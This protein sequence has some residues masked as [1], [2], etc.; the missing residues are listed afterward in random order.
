MKQ[1][2]KQNY[3]QGTTGLEPGNSITKAKCY[4]TELL[5]TALP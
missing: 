3:K 1:K 4:T 2:P 5:P